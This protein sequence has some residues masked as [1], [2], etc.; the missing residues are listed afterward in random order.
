MMFDTLET[1]RLMSVSLNAATH[2]LTIQGT[3]GAD[4]ITVDVANGKVNV[5]DNGVK[6]S[7]VKAN[8]AKIVAF[9]KAGNDSIKL[10]PN[11]FIPAELHSGPV[12][13]PNGEDLQ[14]GSGNDLIF[15]DDAFA[16]GRG[17]AGNDAFVV[18]GDNNFVYGDAGNDTVRLAGEATYSGENAFRGGPGVDAIDYGGLTTPVL[19]QNGDAG[20]YALLD[21]VPTPVL[22]VDRLYDFENFAG[23]QGDD[24]L[25][26]G[27]GANVLKGNGGNDNIKGRAGDDKAYGGAGADAL[28]GDDGNDYLQGDAGNDFLS[29]GAGADSLN[30]NDGD[31][32]F[33]SK[34]GNK[35][36]LAG[37][38]GTDK[39][40]RDAMDVVNSVEASQF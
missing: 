26:G 30:G 33:Y 37:G 29:A 23:G 5:T 6:S 35:D 3:A 22:E 20:T 18:F 24:Y 10:T 28:F 40:T 13:D 15:L 19:L 4:A 31:D 11:V 27:A 17:G 12:S 36:F 38:A 32:V 7:F 2:V 1:R 39:A 34:D 8:V 9:G 16:E 14:G 21:G 25:Y